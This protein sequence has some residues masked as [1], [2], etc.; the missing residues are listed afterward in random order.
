MLIDR[1]VGN[2]R[3]GSR[4]WVNKLISYDAES[5]DK[6]IR[7][8]KEQQDYLACPDIRLY[9]A[10]NYR[11]LDKAMKKFVHT[12][13]DMNPIY[14]PR[15]FSRIQDNFVSALMNPTSKETKLWLFDVDLAE[16][17]RSEESL[18]PLM[19]D[20]KNNGIV[21]RYR[22]PTPG[23]WHVVVEPYNK[24]LYTLPNAI[25]LQQDGLVLLRV[26]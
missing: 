4:R 24:S 15:F 13:I 25:T 3:K 12:I 18:N 22:Y 10:M 5:F 14:F 1:S 20:A 23:G 11:N 16:D 26:I 21:E 17:Y 8:L 7:K 19:T 2:S 6:N 9:G